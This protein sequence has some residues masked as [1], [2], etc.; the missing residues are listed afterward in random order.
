M[1]R[2]AINPG[3]PYQWEAVLKTGPN[4]VGRSPA[5]DVHIEHD[6]VSGTHCELIVTGQ[7]VTL[8]D[9]GSTN[10]SFLNRAPVQEA[11][12]LPGQR[13]Q[14][15]G[16]EL[17]L[18]AEAPTL[19]AS[20]STSSAQAPVPP[21]RAPVRIAVP[22]AAASGTAISP[23]PPP[24]IRLAPST[25]AGGPDAAAPPGPPPPIPARTALRVTAHE[26]PPPPPSAPSAYVPDAYD[27]DPA[28]PAMCKY[29]PKSHA[30]YLCPQCQL[31]YC[32]LCVAARPGGTRT[33]R[34]CR[35]C[36]GECVA[37]NVQIVAQVNPHEN[38]FASVP[39]A[40][41]YPFKGMAGLIFLIG[42]A[43]MF[44]ALEFLAMIRI[45][46]GFFMR[47]GLLG[48]VFAYLQKIIHAAALGEDDPPGWPDTSEF[49]QDLLIPGLQLLGTMAVS[50]GPMIGLSMW[51]GLDIMGGGNPDPMKALLIVAAGVFGV[52][53]FP[54]AVL[55]VAMHD[56]IAAVNPILVLVSI[57]KVPLEYL[58]VLVVMG[59]TIGVWML[60]LWLLPLLPIPLVVALASKLMTLYFLTV[61]MR[62]LG[63]MY[64]AKRHKLGWLQ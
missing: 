19:S 13:L 44:A 47:I 33:G 38:F 29:H 23:P 63:L 27:V 51:V 5:C 64:Y 37:L 60:G 12:L 1:P 17:E 48:Y 50:F 15:G 34:F 31:H 53:Y 14:L 41:V 35:R 54:M 25:A 43:I 11:F 28:G 40:F 61:L 26:A 20:P 3:T 45:G 32:E 16:V 8:R 56:S 58:L 21:A 59:A 24:S 10:G 49:V 36:S 57:I 30:R 4:T 39:G 52:I 42:G 62:L 18:L 6:S 2:L 46:G 7:N 9:L 55:A 22:A